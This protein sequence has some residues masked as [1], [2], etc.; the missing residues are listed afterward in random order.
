MSAASCSRHSKI[1]SGSH[2]EGTRTDHYPGGRAA[3]LVPSITQ[4]QPMFSSAVDN[5]HRS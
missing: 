3:N 2:N 4:R 1:S 5:S